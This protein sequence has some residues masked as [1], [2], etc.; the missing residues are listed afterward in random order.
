MS[1]NTV[2]VL[3]F[4][5]IFHLSRA[6]YLLVKLTSSESTGNKLEKGPKVFFCHI[7]YLR[8]SLPSDSLDRGVT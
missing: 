5:F 8:V 1:T 7:P 4:Y 3:T 6:S 2:I